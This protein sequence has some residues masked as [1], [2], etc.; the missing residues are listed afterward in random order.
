M[1]VTAFGTFGAGGNAAIVAGAF[2]FYL[3]DL[4]VARQRFV[5]QSLVNR[6]WGLPLYY[7]AQ[8]ILGYSTRAS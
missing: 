2:A 8:L 7:V 3:S 4:S 1:V 6:L 5:V